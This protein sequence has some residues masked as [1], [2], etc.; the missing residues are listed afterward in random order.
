MYSQICNQTALDLLVLLTYCTTCLCMLTPQ[1]DLKAN[2]T[3]HLQRYGVSLSGV[4]SYHLHGRGRLDQ[5]CGIIIM[6]Y[7]LC[8]VH[9]FDTAFCVLHCNK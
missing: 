3:A 5:N 9:Y 2:R 1:E 7:F 8:F 4:I 6:L